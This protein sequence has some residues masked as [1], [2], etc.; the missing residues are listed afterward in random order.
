MAGFALFPTD[1]GP[2]GVAWTERGLVGVQLPQASAGATT[3]RLRRRF[4]ALQQAD[5]PQPV[6]RA[7]A[8]MTA[9]LA[10]ACVDFS[11]A[12][13]DFRDIGP[14]EQAVYAVARTIPVGATLTYGEMAAQLGDAAQARAVGQALGRNPL[15]IIVP[16]HRVVG[17]G[18]RTG[19]FSAPGGIKTKLRILE[20]ESRHAPLP[21]FAGLPTSN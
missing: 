17:A 16:C 15:P 4:P 21:L 18:G 13:I 7:V 8:G 20:I 14:W 12:E 19:G 1:I 5:P 10:G 11:D 3:A 6:A 9:L 2:C